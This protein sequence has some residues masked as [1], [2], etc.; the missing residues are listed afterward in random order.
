MSIRFS[1][2]IPAVSCAVLL[3]ACGGGSGGGNAP[4]VIADPDPE[5]AFFNDD[6]KLGYV[7]SMLGRFLSVFRPISNLT[8]DTLGKRTNAMTETDNVSCSGGGSIQM[9]IT[10]DGTENALPDALSIS[11]N[12]CVEDGETSNGSIALS[13]NLDDT[14][15][16]GTITITASNFTVTGGEEDIAM[17]GGVTV[18]MQSTD[19]SDTFSISGSNFSLSAGGESI[20]ISDYNITAIDNFSADSSSLEAGMTVSS[21]VDGTV[22]FLVDPPLLINGFDEYPSSGTVTMT[23]S[24]G[25]SLTMNASN[26]D[27]ATFDYIISDGTTTS[28]GVLRWDEAGF[29]DLLDSE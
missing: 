28:S 26:G 22:T 9:S 4:V 18:A 27:L 10:S 1:R 15:D 13:M 16:N 23:H 17:N 29:E 3:T 25:S 14:G 11:F 12:N 24:D 5:V 19:S 6:A 2:V 8:G 7:D 20:S 21:D